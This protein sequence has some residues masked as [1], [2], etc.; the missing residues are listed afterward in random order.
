M[1]LETIG[2]KVAI[3]LATSWLK[4]F[5]EEKLPSKQMRR[6]WVAS[7][8]AGSKTLY[9]VSV[10]YLYRIKLDD[11]YLLVRGKRIDQFQPVG[12]VRKWYTP[13]IDALES[14]GVRDDDCLPIDDTSRH[15]LRVRVPGK[16]IF[17]FLKWYNK[18]KHREVDQTRE[19]QEELVK[20]GLLPADKFATIDVRY[21]Y[22][23]PTFHYSQYFKSQELLYH[24][25]YELMP[26]ASQEAAL[27][28]MQQQDHLD[29]K[30]VTE[31]LIESLG[32]D[33]RLKNKPFAIGEHAK[34]LISNTTKIFSE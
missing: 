30:W 3:S 22:T 32:Y 16:N 29:Y 20:P 25:V 5:T 11:K 4:K 7:K 34:L 23:V 14:M 8:F 17:E 18:Q 24:E 2:Q 15:D 21:L 31:D 33:I 13:A 6:L 12:G 28:A 27:R 10:G 19:F 9:R 26:T 1:I